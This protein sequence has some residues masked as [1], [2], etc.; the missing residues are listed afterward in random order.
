MFGIIA[1][2]F[3]MFTIFLQIGLGYGV[4]KAGLSGIPFS[5]GIAL[6]AG[7]AGP[8]FVPKLGRWSLTSGALVMVAGMG[9]LAAAA[10]YYGGDLTPWEMIPGLFLSG[11][12]MGM[13]VAPIVVFILAEVP[14]AHAGSGSGIVNAVGQIGGAVGVA[15]LGVIF[16]GVLAS[17]ADRASDSVRDALAADLQA[18]SIGEP[19][20]GFVISG[21]QSCFR[22][23]SA[24]K[25]PSEVPPSCQPP[26]GFT[27]PPAV[28]AALDTQGQVANQRNFTAAFIHTLWYEI[29][30]LL[31]IFLLTFLLP[32][33]VR[34]DQDIP[35]H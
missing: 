6:T 12:G 33:H 20:Q 21:F 8:I 19:I 31:V 17:G 4:L 7:L 5:I 2:F 15:V 23:R 24:A 13:I 30:A 34:L 35:A 9:L 32:R 29:G 3:L 18:A 27:M 22:D 10:W 14:I 26:A 16:F 28:T 25:D 11:A 1:G